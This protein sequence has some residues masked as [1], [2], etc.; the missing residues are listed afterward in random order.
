MDDEYASLGPGVMDLAAARAPRPI[1]D[2]SVIHGR[3]IMT[4]AFVAILP[5]APPPPGG[6]ASRTLRRNPKGGIYAIIVHRP[7]HLHC[8]WSSGPVR[9]CAAQRVVAA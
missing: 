2:R 5:R 3:F 1:N 7:H 6:I 9:L 4:I 8:A